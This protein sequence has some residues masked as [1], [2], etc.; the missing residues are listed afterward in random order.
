MTHQDEA[1]RERLTQIA[2]RAD[3]GAAADPGG[4]LDRGVRAL[5]RRAAV[6][7][8]WSALAVAA[9]VGAVVTLGPGGTVTRTDPPVAAGES[10]TP[11]AS[12]TPTPTPS[13][14]PD[15]AAGKALQ[16]ERAAQRRI[17]DEWITTR[18]MDTHRVGSPFQAWRDGL[19]AISADVLD[20]RG[21]H[22][23]YATNSLQSGYGGAGVSLGIRMGWRTPG[24]AGQGMVAVAVSDREPVDEGDPC[25]SIGVNCTRESTF[26][27]VPVRLSDDGSTVVAI[28]PDGLV[29]MVHVQLVF[30]NNTQ[31]GVSRM[32]LTDADLLTLALDKRID[33]PG[34]GQ[35][36]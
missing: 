3:L 27:G 14:S 17:R 29:V 20:P 1:L 33:L 23:D 18:L 30:G 10:A 11:S 25:F 22:L 24:E 35:V 36:D 13:A 5:H 32:P 7:A 19:F 31:V 6:R 26:R 34:P 4:D 21:G 2:D 15:P 9:V 28:R 12:P 8:G 16:A